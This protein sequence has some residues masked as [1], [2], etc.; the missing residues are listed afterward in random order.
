MYRSI[1]SKYTEMYKCRILATISNSLIPY[2]T[3]RVLTSSCSFIVLQVPHTYL[4]FVSRCF[5]ASA[6][7][8]WNSLPES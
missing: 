5:S 2:R 1:H 7:T 3:S 6:P 8:I 4:I